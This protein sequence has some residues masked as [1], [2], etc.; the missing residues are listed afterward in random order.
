[1]LTAVPDIFNGDRT[2]LEKESYFLFLLN[3]RNS[4]NYPHYG[5]NNYL[6]HHT[7]IKSHETT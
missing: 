3:G 6:F 4:L 1:M 7:E 2:T 5:G